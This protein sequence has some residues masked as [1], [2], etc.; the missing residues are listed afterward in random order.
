MHDSS[1]DPVALVR[2]YAEAKSRADIDAAL[3]LCRDDVVF[4]TIPFQA[5]A[6]GV[7]DARRQFVVFF[8][9]FPDY[10]VEVDDVVAKD[11]KVVV[12]GTIRATMLG[13]LV[14]VGPTDRRYELPFMG[15]WWVDDGAILRERLFFDLN[16]M[17]EQLG[18]STELVAGRLRASRRLAERGAG[19]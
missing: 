12:T 4:E 14:D 16:Q 5:V 1:P 8:R 13:A 6:R 15:L 2:S 11:E 17:C 10:D 19:S 7:A 18:V 9:A 3:A